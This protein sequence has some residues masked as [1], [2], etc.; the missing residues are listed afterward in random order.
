MTC[1][2]GT[3]RNAAPVFRQRVQEAGQLLAQLQGTSLDH[4]AP[5]A[6][7]DPQNSVPTYGPV[8][9]YFDSTM[10]SMMWGH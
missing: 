2:A 7:L 4:S 9:S 8:Q 5:P 1:S 6:N 3:R 10:N